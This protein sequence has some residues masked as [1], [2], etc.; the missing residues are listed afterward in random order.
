[1]SQHLPWNGMADGYGR[2][3]WQEFALANFD[4]PADASFTASVRREAEHFLS[5]TRRF[6]SL[7]APCCGSKVDQ[8]GATPALPP[9]RRAQTLLTQQL[10]SGSSGRS[11]TC[12]R[13]RAGVQLMPWEHSKPLGTASRVLCATVAATTI[14]EGLHGLHMHLIK[15]DC[16]AHRCPSRTR[17]PS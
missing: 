12:G 13:V 6:A 2:L 11:R 4:Y 14:D 15:P 9:V 5:R 3:I 1:M 16:R 10:P 8:Q 17:M 7:G